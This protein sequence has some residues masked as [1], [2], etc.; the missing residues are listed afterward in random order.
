MYMLTVNSIVSYA[1]ENWNFI[2]EATNVGNSRMQLRGLV[3][4]NERFAKAF[5]VSILHN[6]L[7]GDKEP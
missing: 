3:Y 1:S 2:V 7:A 4:C 5:E 6:N